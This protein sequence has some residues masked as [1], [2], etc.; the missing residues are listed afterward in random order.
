MQRTAPVPALNLA[1]GLTRLLQS[2]VR[3]DVDE[4][5]QNRIQPF[6]PGKA[7]FGQ[8][9]WGQLARPQ[10]AGEIENCGWHFAPRGQRSV[11][12][13]LD[14]EASQTRDSLCR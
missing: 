12:G 14:E 11:V 3:S 10:L 13:Q 6:D 1:L 7:D 9:D 4:S 2:R 5:I 8:F